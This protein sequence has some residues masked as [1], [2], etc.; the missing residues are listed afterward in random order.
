VTDI[1][2]VLEPDGVLVCGECRTA[3]RQRGAGGVPTLVVVA[4]S[5]ARHQ[6][7]SHADSEQAK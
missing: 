7:E 3:I 2:F 1:W 5:A 6:A 4:N